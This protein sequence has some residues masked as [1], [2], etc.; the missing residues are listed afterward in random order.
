M[1]VGVHAHP[2]S[3]HL[4][5]PVKLQCTL[6]A[7]I[8]YLW[9]LWHVFIRTRRAAYLKFINLTFPTSNWGLIPPPP[10]FF[11]KVFHK[12]LGL[13]LLCRRTATAWCCCGGDDE[14]WN[15]VGDFA[16]AHNHRLPDW[17]WGGGRGYLF[18]I[19]MHVK[20]WFGYTTVNS[21][22]AAHKMCH[23]MNL[24]SRLLY[25][26]IKGTEN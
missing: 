13:W 7:Y 16:L 15:T 24:S 8:A 26:N 3:L 17:M 2:L 11:E 18:L 19:H 22:M 9:L 1:R 25:D 23:V 20:K 10:S 4:P 21:A 12:S 5:S 6:L 14:D